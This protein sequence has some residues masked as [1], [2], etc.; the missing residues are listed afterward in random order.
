MKLRVIAAFALVVVLAYVLF[1]ALDSMGSQGSSA[2]GLVNVVG[3]T[4][5][6]VGVLAAGII[7][8]RAARP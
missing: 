7:M 2:F 6:V 4:T 1:F 8:R 3:L 5:V